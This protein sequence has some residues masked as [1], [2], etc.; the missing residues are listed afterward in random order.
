MHATKKYFHQEISYN[1]TV[2]NAEYRY[3]ILQYMRLLAVAERV[4][5]SR[6]RFERSSVRQL[7]T[8]S[9]I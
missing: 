5:L 1:R 3:R 7:R 8:G 2:R 6:E 4:H 9:N